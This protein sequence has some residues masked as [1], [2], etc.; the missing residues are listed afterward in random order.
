MAVAVAV[1]LVLAAGAMA[2]TYGTVSVNLVSISPGLTM[3]SMIQPY[4][5]DWY[6]GATGHFNLQYL[7]MPPVLLNTAAS[8]V[9]PQTVGV[10]GTYTY[11][12]V[13]PW[14]VPVPDGPADQSGGPM[15]VAKANYLREFWALAFPSVTNN[16]TGAA[17]QLGV[18]EIVFEDLPLTNWDVTVGKFKARDDGGNTTLAIT[19]ANT[20]LALVDGTGPKATLYGL[21]SSSA[22]DYIVSPEPATLAFVAL[23]GVGMLLRRRHR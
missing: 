22:Q 23:G 21:Q 10:G 13:D 14:D 17:F 9:E 2:S 15:G 1:S 7:T 11:N 5:T 4:D 18:W 19:Q 16:V 12:V 20:W 8:C 3:S 6:S